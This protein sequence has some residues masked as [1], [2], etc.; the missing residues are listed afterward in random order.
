MNTKNGIEAVVTAHI[1]LIT[2][3]HEEHHY[4]NTYIVAFV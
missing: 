4:S 3:V 2:L 1:G